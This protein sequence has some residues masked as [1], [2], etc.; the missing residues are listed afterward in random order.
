MLNFNRELTFRGPWLDTSARSDRND[1]ASLE[2]CCGLTVVR[3]YAEAIIMGEWCNSII[4]IN[5]DWIIIISRL[6]I[7]L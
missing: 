4:I 1:A 2:K 5:I 7:V 6:L 3:G